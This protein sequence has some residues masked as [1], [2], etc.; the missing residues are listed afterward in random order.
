METKLEKCKGT[1]TEQKESHLCFASLRKALCNLE[2][3]ADK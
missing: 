3:K 2:A 1:H